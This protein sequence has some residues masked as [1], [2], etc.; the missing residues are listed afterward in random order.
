MIIVDTSIW[1]EFFKGNEPCF[2]KLE[3]LLD[4]NKV[5]AV[6]CV[7]AELM[8]GAKGEREQKVL[9]DY[10]VSLPKVPGEHLLYKAGIEASKNKWFSKGVGLIDASLVVMGRETRSRIWSLDKKL[11]ATLNKNECF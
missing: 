1:I 10:W 7:F 9:N 8:Q 11:N 5:F 3:E 4:T 2:S 6:E